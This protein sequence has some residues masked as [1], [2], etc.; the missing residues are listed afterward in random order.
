M[1]EL[2]DKKNCCGC[3]ACASVCARRA[4]TMR[5][6]EEGFRYP[7]VDVALC[8]NC[9]LCERVCPVLNQGESRVPIAVYAAKNR[10][11]N[12]RRESSSGGVFVLLARQ[13][14][15][16]GGVVFGAKFDA[17]W[18]VVHDY[19]ETFEGV[20]AFMG[21]KYVQSDIGDNF[22]KV[23]QFLAANRRVLFSGTPCQVAGLKRFLRKEYDNLLTV[24]VACHGVPSPKVW[25]DYLEYRRAQHVVG[26]NSVPLS[27]NERP[28]ITAISFRDK[29]NG[30]KKYGFRICFA[31]FE[32]AKNTVSESAYKTYSETTY[33]RKDTFMKGFLDNLYLRP[34]CYCCAARRGKSG[35]DI[36]IADYWGLKKFHKEFTDNRGVSAVLIY[37]E[38]GR[39]AFNAVETES[40]ES[41]YEYVLRRNSCLEHSVSRPVEA[42]QFWQDYSRYG[43]SAIT[44]LCRQIHRSRF[45]RMCD[46]LGRALK[47]ILLTRKD[48][49]RN[50]NTGTAG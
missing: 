7:V 26:K 28:K 22:E 14:I 16:E 44:P 37:D 38:A 46:A 8:N 30:W 29:A 10:D 27:L 43:I 18:R 47:R 2:H 17:D 9:G 32:A 35:A 31:A 23:K 4:I 25:R 34:S 20:E 21:S 12:I 40:I 42:D 45:G 13:T 3:T 15:S 5:E 1:I 36:S 33:F 39:Q 50:C 41:R 24:E 48:E 19:A 11:E 49:D 6:D